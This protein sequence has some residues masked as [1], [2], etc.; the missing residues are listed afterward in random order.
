MA[1]FSASPL[2]FRCFE[3]RDWV[4]PLSWPLT[5]LEAF[6]KGRRSHICEQLA[7]VRAAGRQQRTLSS[8]GEMPEGQYGFQRRME[9]EVEGTGKRAVVGRMGKND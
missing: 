5:K 7:A 4:L 8:T 2:E 9:L 6:A 1:W 3:G